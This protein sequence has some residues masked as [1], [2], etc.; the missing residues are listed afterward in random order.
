MQAPIIIDFGTDSK[1]T[2]FSCVLGC[3]QCCGYAYFLPSELEHL[4]FNIKQNLVL[5]EDKYEVIKKDGR[6]KFYD[7]K[8]E[9]SSFCTIYESRPIRC[10]IYPYFPLI[11][12]RRIVITLELA[13]KMLKDKNYRG[14]CPGIGNQ[15]K[16]L[17]YTIRD[18]IVFLEKLSDSPSLLATI[19]LE[20]DAFSNI[21][22]DR[23]FIE[24]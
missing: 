11:V 7:N 9:S 6:C 10:R 15:G 18:C 22:N 8:S 4:P 24:Q 12:E 16:P 13:V 14:S 5:K 21:R 1:F 23:W 2:Q 17:K 19:I 3:H 20:S